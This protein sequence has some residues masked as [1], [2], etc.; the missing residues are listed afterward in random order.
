MAFTWLLYRLTLSIRN[1]ILLP[2]IVPLKECVNYETYFVI[3][4]P[5]PNS[6][7]IRTTCAQMRDFF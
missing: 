6:L 7:K 5:M 3:I 4:V 1:F 2:L